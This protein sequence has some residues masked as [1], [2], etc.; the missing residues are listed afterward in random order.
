MSKILVFTGHTSL[1]IGSLE[2][3]AAR[4]STAVNADATSTMLLVENDYRQAPDSVRSYFKKSGTRVY[5]GVIRTNFTGAV[6]DILRVI[7]HYKPDVVHVNFQPV[8]YVAAVVAKLSGVKHVF[9]T[10]H[11][12]VMVKRYSRTWWFH[13][14]ASLCTSKIFC[15][16]NAVDKELGEL[17]IGNGKRSV[18]P[19]GINLERF[20]AAKITESERARVRDE[21]G[22]GDDFVITIVAQIRPVKKL[23]TFL[24]IM[25]ILVNEDG[26][27]NIK[28]FIVGGTYDSEESR[29]LEEEYLDF[30]KSLSLE[31]SI[32][33]LGVRDDVQVL[34]AVSHLSG[35]TSESEGLPLALVEAAAM[36]LP[37]FGTDA[38]GIPEV[39]VDGQNGV[40]APIDDA[41]KLA[42]RIKELI[43]DDTIRANYARN[44]RQL[45]S[46]LYDMN[47][48]V[49][50]Y[51]Q[52]YRGTS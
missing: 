20:S 2:D 26:I 40:V 45:V 23:D 16:S 4:M 34:Y 38:G 36:G 22:I 13:K 9:W 44:S 25:N 7:R 43:H 50:K 19:I 11:S 52:F 47:Q 6:R 33:F 8:S 28:A 46:V 18:L 32:R 27:R 31:K 39:V 30:V 37:L 3:F 15:V 48:Q 12:R 49:D 51:V 17:G 5:R 41:Q 14:I 24:S 42:A 1:K 21:L 10:K 35:L 29:R